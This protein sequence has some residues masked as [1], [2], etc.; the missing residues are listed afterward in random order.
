M[1]NASGEREFYDGIGMAR[2]GWLPVK[3]RSGLK[4]LH[5]RKIVSTHELQTIGRQF[6][7]LEPQRDLIVKHVISKAL[8]LHSA[9]KHRSAVEHLLTHTASKDALDDYI[10]P[11]RI[12]FECTG[13]THKGMKRSSNDDVC[14]IHPEKQLFVVADGMGGH[15]NGYKAASTA[16]AALANHFD[17]KEPSTLLE[18]IHKAHQAVVEKN[19]ETKR[20][21]K[22]EE[23]KGVYYTD[24][25]KHKL[26]MGTTLTALHIEKDGKAHVVH[27]GDTRVYLLRKGILAHKLSQLTTDHSLPGVQNQLL[28]AVGG[29][30]G[31]EPEYKTVQAKNGD[32]FFLCS[33]GI[34]K[35]V[36][37]REIKNA[38]VKYAR[39][40]ITHTDLI[41]YL[42]KTANK[43]GGPDNSTA[44]VVKVKMPKK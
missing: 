29:E 26:M 25:A 14:L 11:V 10:N 4:E 43:R 12:S 33:D 1:V 37:D 27:V 8:E 19:E 15:A 5:D 32:V 30:N 35:R 34:N 38:L 44:L 39:G 13:A 22:A 41:K 6:S 20:G 42:I 16:V 18:G 3:L 7:A 28:Q 23:R 2:W 9:G 40:K 36:T 21:I 24:E 31:I 17:T